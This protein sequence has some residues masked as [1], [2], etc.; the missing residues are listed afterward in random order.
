M[1]LGRIVGA[2]V[3]TGVVLAGVA[4]LR[5]P[6]ARAQAQAGEKPRAKFE[7]YKDRAGEFR[8]RLRAQNTQVLAGS[9]QGYTTKRDCLS[10]IESVKRAV[11]EAPVED[12]GEAG[13]GTGDG[14]AERPAEPP[15]Q[16]RRGTK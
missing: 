14:A 15:Q 13:A 6:A 16:G 7:V 10:G 11:A 1:R 9:G 5:A 8:W 3:L 12:M 2:V 4:L